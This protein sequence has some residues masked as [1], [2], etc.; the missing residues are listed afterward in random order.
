MSEAS[1]SPHYERGFLLFKVTHLPGGLGHVTHGDGAW[2]HTCC[3]G[4]TDSESDIITTTTVITCML[5][6][7]TLFLHPLKMSSNSYILLRVLGIS[8]LNPSPIPFCLSSLQSGEHSR[9]CV[10]LSFIE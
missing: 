6:I 1:G 5:V 7:I 3:P 9:V 10:A 4:G 8:L 2:E